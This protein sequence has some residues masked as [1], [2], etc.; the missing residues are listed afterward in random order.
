MDLSFKRLIEISTSI[1]TNLIV[2]NDKFSINKQKTSGYL[3][4]DGDYNEEQLEYAKLDD[5]KS[6]AKT[7]SIDEIRAYKDLLFKYNQNVLNRARKKLFKLCIAI[8]IIFI[9]IS[10]IAKVPIF[11]GVVVVFTAIVYFVTNR[12]MKRIFHICNEKKKFLNKS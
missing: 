5:S 7:Y 8:N 2:K 4:K 10:L 12:Y 1:L 3:N 9:M 11:I 6:K